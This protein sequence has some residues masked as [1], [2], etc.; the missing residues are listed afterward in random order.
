[1][2]DALHLAAL[3]AELRTLIHAVKVGPAALLTVAAAAALC[4]VS[5]ATMRRWLAMGE[6]APVV[7]GG[8]TMVPR[9]EIERLATPLARGPLPIAPTPRAPR[10]RQPAL[11]EAEKVLAAL[12]D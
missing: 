1:M 2:S 3:V 5:P 8:R 10:P 11:A 9:A 7:V 6:L 12:R 4:S